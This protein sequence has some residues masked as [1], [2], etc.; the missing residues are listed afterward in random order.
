MYKKPC[1][2]YLSLWSQFEYH[3]TKQSGMSKPQAHIDV[4]THKISWKW[5]YFDVFSKYLLC[6]CNHNS[7][8]L[9]V[10]IIK[11]IMPY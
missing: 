3:V 11:K 1:T 5:S 7:N 6:Q 2:T 4:T 9:S 8:F 10:F